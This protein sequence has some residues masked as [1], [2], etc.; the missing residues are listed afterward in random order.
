MRGTMQLFPTRI[1]IVRNDCIVPIIPYD[2][3]N[4]M[5]MIRHNYEC[6]DYDFRPHFTCFDDFIFG[7][8]SICIQNY[9][10]ILNIVQMIFPILHA[11][12]EKIRTLGRIIKR[13]QSL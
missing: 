7:D 10:P 11:K 3:H 2:E 9:L 1:C 4:H 6:I 12:C 5:N 13:S 8:F